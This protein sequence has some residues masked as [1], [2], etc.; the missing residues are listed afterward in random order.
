MIRLRLRRAIRVLVRRD[1]DRRRRLPQTDIRREQRVDPI[2][3][4]L[5]DGG[6]ARGEDDLQIATGEVQF[7]L[8]PGVTGEFDELAMPQGLLDDGQGE[9]TAGPAGDDEDLVEAV[10]AG[11]IGHGGAGGE[12]GLEAAVGAFDEDAFGEAGVFGCEAG[13]AGGGAFF[14]LDVED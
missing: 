2:D 7:L 11:G 6:T 13:E 4:P 10:H 12:L 5:R 1:I 8:L 9:A 14:G 3:I